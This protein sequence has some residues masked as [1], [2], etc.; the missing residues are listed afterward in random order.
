M[1]NFLLLFFILLMNF[2]Y[3]QIFIY[4]AKKFST[5]DLTNENPN[6]TRWNKI[7]AI[8]VF[9]TDS[10][11]VDSLEIQRKVIIYS[12]IYQEINLN[13]LNSYNVD[14]DGNYTFDFIG[15]DIWGNDCD[16]SYAYYKKR[17][18]FIVSYKGFAVKFILRK[19]RWS[20][21]NLKTRQVSFSSVTKN[22]NNISG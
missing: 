12:N 13:L 9:R 18:Y 5:I 2:S 8:V 14:S 10:V 3:S 20:S 1:K 17:I 4:R 7:D 6:W 22:S 19:K 15:T 21:V 11:Y 16:F